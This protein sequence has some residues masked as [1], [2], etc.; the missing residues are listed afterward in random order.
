MTDQPILPREVFSQLTQPGPRRPWLENWLINEVWSRARFEAVQD[1]VQDYL[2]P[3]ERAVKGV[4]ELLAA[5]AMRAYDE[6]LAAPPPER[7]LWHFLEAERPSAAVVFDGLSLRETPALLRL[8]AA[9][10]FKVK[11]IGCSVAAVPSET[12]DFTH[13]RLRL[14]SRTS[15]INLPG[16]GELQAAGIGCV[17]FNS[18]HERRVLNSSAPALLLWSAFPDQTYRDADARFD[19]QFANI[20]TYLDTAWQNTVQQIPRGRP[21]LVTSDHGYIFFGAG[22]SAPRSHAGLRPIASRFGGERFL[23]L[24]ADDPVP[25]HADV[26]VIPSHSVAMIR[27]RVQVHTSGPDANKLYKHGG[28]SLMEMLTPWIVLEP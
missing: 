26:A 19:R 8:A 17:Y 15:P 13:Q 20:Q 1:I 24:K 12:S 28:L 22:L 3:G 7:D 10:G 2:W 16:R 18:P 9:S 23:R 21:I 5:A 11:E 4:E 27:G 14:S 6:L 25:D